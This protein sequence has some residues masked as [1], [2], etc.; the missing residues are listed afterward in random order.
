MTAALSKRNAAQNI[1]HGTY[2][3][4]KSTLKYGV[5]KLTSINRDNSAAVRD[6]ARQDMKK[7]DKQFVQAGDD[8]KTAGRQIKKA[9]SNEGKPQ[10]STMARDVFGN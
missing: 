2:L 10:G 5:A 7:A 1:A 6:Q 8:F 9:L 3:G 4:V